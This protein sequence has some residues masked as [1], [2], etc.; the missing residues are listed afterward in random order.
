MKIPVL[1]P[2]E[3]HYLE[4]FSLAAFADLGKDSPAARALADALA[5]QAIQDLHNVV[6]AK[7]TEIVHQLN[8]A[9][10]ALRK[11]GPN[12]KGEYEYRSC[13]DGDCHDDCDL[14]F[15]VD[16]IVSTGYSHLFKGG[17]SAT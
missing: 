15:A 1:H 8:G 5:A 11:Y 12:P 16:V 13:P 14:R 9:G 7:V 4:K 6:Q 2:M 3:N 10:H 17:N